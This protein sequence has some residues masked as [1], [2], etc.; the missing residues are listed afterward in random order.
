M[1]EELPK[2]IMEGEIKLGCFTLKVHTLEDGRALI[3]EESMIAFLEW[4]GSGEMLRLPK[5]DVDAFV[6]ELHKLKL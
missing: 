3:A 1:S 6:E 5:K 4:L 2:S